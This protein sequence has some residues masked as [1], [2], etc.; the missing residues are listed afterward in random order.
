MTA[1]LDL[2]AIAQF[3]AERMVGCLVEGVILTAFAGLLLRVIG[4]QNSGTR[5]AVW[6]SVL[7]AIPA[8][9]MSGGV[10]ASAPGHGPATTVP[11]ISM[12]ASWALYLL[13]AWALLASVGLLRVA[14]GLWHLYRLRKS[15]IAIEATSLDRPLQE[16][17]RRFQASRAV[18]ICVSEQV[19]APTAVGL[20]KPA[21]VI[22]E[23]LMRELST[24]ELQQVMLHEL[25]HLRRRDD[26]TNLFQKILKALLFFHPAVWWVEQ[27]IS[28]EREMACDDAVLAE[29]ADPR[30]YAQC[31]VHLAE[32]SL[33]RRSLALAQAAVSRIGQT[34]RRVV[35]ILDGDRPRTTQVWKPA[36][37]LVAVVS[38]A[39]LVFL[40][41]APQLVAFRDGT[42]GV[43]A[44]AAAVAP[45][46][47]AAAKEPVPAGV[48]DAAPKPAPRRMQ[49]SPQVLA[50]K[51]HAKSTALQRDDSAFESRLA[52]QTVAPAVVP[53][54]SADEGM[55]PPATFLVF[56]ESR[57]YGAYGLLEWQVAV[58]RITV[59]QQTDS[60]TAKGITR[61]S[62]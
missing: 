5:F 29:T 26:W 37:S 53:A 61:K 57:S 8:L 36:V 47:Q 25:T 51:M 30:T 23:W 32:K 41:W 54:R 45:V 35:Q 12:R 31:L 18:T 34:S 11:V 9:A 55:M 17:L 27:R 43:V 7:L 19:Q 56:V 52:Q 21:V 49:A 22:P 60:P 46:L 6:F 62:I 15:C 1:A 38:C 33:V 59:Q 40:G 4:R 2:N 44:N 39:S 28:L 13:G 58:W 50:A 48:Q 24:Q 3:S 42:A 20:L 16:M 14:V 10:W